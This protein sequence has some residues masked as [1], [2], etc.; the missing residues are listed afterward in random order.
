M[1]SALALLALLAGRH[2]IHSS[3]ASLT[4]TPGAARATLLLR[5]FAEDFP[6][7]R[8]AGATERY[9]AARFALSDAA[10][11]ALP[12]R[13]EAARLEGPVLTL[14]LSVAVPRGLSGLRIWHGVLAE[15]FSDQVNLLQARYGGRSL[16]LLFTAGDGPKPL[17]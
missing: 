8:D 7:G 16:S 5:V 1:L 13:L 15:R 4:L 3:S 10:G 2:P 14:Q 11:R 6:P 17:P 9:L 12:L